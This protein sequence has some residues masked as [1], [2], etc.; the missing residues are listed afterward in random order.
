M[1][2]PCPCIV[3]VM[4][5]CLLAIKLS[6]CAA[7]A[8]AEVSKTDLEMFVATIKALQENY[9]S[10]NAVEGGRAPIKLT[11]PE[12]VLWIWVNPHFW[13]DVP[14]EEIMNRRV[15]LLRMLMENLQDRI[16]DRPVKWSEQKMQDIA[17]GRTQAKP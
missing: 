10:L 3:V 14:L 15:P 4:L 13:S 1:T 9:D 17:Y 6:G 5:C 7:P 12:K 8:L 2:K 11:G 16:L